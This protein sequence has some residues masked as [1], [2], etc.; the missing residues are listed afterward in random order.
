MQIDA[1]MKKSVISCEAQESLLRAAGAMW[2]HD[3]GWLP[4][5]ESDASGRRR[6][7]G[8][9]T[10]RDIAMCALFE[11]RPLSQLRVSDVMAKD[12]VTCR[13]TDTVKQAHA[14]MRSRRVRRVPVVDAQD[15]LVGV[16]SLADLA[17]QAIELTSGGRTTAQLEVGYTLA[18][19]SSAEAR[20]AAALRRAGAQ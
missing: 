4:V 9:I 19:I 16:L 17:R 13:A 1:L 11:D 14:I 2:D 12:P 15:A 6:V 3:C 18:A 7:V 5:C 20:E 8:V 10:D